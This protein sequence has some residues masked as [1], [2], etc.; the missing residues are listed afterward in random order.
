[1]NYAK[2]VL[3]TLVVVVFSLTAFAQ[4][5]HAAGGSVGRAW[6]TARPLPIMET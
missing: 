2:T 3:V 4:Y 5:G 6:V 1:M